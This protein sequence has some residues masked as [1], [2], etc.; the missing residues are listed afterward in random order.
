MTLSDNWHSLSREAQFAAESMAIGV[1]ALGRA[2]Y[3]HNANYAQ[4]LFALSIGLERAAKLI[5]CIAHLGRHGTFPSSRKIRNYGHDLESLLAEVDRVCS[6]MPKTTRDCRLPSSAICT[7]IIRILSD[8][9]TN[10]TRCYNFDA[11]THARTGKSYDPIS[12][13]QKRVSEEVLRKHLT[14]K[15]EAR[16]TARAKEAALIEGQV[17]VIHSSEDRKPIDSVYAATLR[18]ELGSIE[19]PYTRMYVL[20]I[21]RFVARAM[22]EVSR[23]TRAVGTVEIPHMSEI[24]RIFLFDDTAFRSRKTW[25]IY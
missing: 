20:R 11:I 5:L 16:T 2:S 3:A 19:K 12:A 18:T 1:T 17:S 7:A 25:S 15:Q 9:A 14:K 21:C 13:W 24:F 8:F 10:V 23:V 4:M 6:T 22:I